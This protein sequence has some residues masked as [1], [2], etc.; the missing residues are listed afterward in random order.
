MRSGTW[1]SAEIVRFQ[2]GVELY[3]WG[4]WIKVAEI[5]Q[6]RSIPSVRTFSQSRMGQ[7]FKVSETL[8]SYHQLAKVALNVSNGLREHELK[9]SKGVI[10][11]DD[12]EELG[13]ELPA[14]AAA[15]G[16]SL[17]LNGGLDGSLAE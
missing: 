6:T 16:E 9:M 2:E 7:S 11:L 15:E 4:N 17:S 8:S 14:A 5:I 12:T 10:G 1:E 13:A 3:G